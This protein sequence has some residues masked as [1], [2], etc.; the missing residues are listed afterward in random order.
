MKNVSHKKSWNL[1]M[2][3]VHVEPPSI[4]LVKVKYDGKSQKYFIKLK[5][6]RYPTPSTSD[7]Y[8]FK[9]CLFENGKP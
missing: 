5:L 9:L 7:P 6:L 3:Q 1:G 8:E 2:T 4:H